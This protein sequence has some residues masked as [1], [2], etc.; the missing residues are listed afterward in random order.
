M[1]PPW[2][3]GDAL[4]SLW[5]PGWRVLYIP[6]CRF[7]CCCLYFSVDPNILTL[8]TAMSPGPQTRL[9]RH[10]CTWA[11]DDFQQWLSHYPGI[12]LPACVLHSH[13]NDTHVLCRGG[14]EE[15][16]IHLRLTHHCGNTVFCALHLRLFL[17][18]HGPPT[19][20]AISVMFTGISSLLGPLIYTLRNQEMESAM[21]R[22]K[23]RLKPSVKE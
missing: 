4:P 11:P 18:L 23:R 1:W 2:V 21:K 16:L 19:D 3:G 7:P 8:F 13:P 6:S 17:A 10:L 12:C 20:K 22:L 15:S 5:H 14:Q 9:Y